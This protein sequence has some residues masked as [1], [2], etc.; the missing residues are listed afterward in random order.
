[1]I[2]AVLAD[3][4]PLY[5][6]NDERDEHHERALRELEELSRDRR[7]ILIPYSILLEAYSLLLIKLGAGAALAW[8]AEVADAPFVNLTAEDY[9]RGFM[10]VRTLADQ[11]ISLVD[12][13][14]AAL[15]SRMELEV[16][17]YDHHFDVMRVPVW[18]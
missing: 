14:L 8:L 11:R 7:E 9:T 10:T 5:A 15:A 16:W 4:G 6:A 1:M 12:A 3:T 18:R 17:T 13:T 2:R